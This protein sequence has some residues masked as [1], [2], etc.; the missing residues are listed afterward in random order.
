MFILRPKIDG[1]TLLSSRR[2]LVKRLGRKDPSYCLVNKQEI[3]HEDLNSF[4]PTILCPGRKVR[5]LVVSSENGGLRTVNLAPSPSDCRTR[6][7]AI[8][9]LE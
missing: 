4:P 8:I 3:V 7:K 6:I 5:I 2:L 9:F 1:V